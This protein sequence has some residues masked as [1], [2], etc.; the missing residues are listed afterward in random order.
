MP[1]LLTRV[2]IFLLVLVGAL[3]VL[4]Q[5]LRRTSMFYPSPY[6]IGNWSADAYGIRP[7]DEWFRT[8]D[9][10]RLHGW[11]F[12]AADPQAPLIV[13]FH[14]NGGNITDRAPIAVDLARAGASVLLFDYRGYG[15][16]EG[17]ASE[18]ALYDD[19]D[20]AYRL[21]TNEL[22]VPPERIVLYGE[23]LGGPYAA[24]VVSTEKARC[25][26]IENSFPSLSAMGNAMYHPLPAGIFVPGAMATAKW[27]NAAKLPVLILHGKR[28]QVIP[29]ALG[30]Q[31]FD[32][33]RV[34]KRMFVS[35]RAGHCEIPEVEG[36]R[37][38]AAV[39]DFI[40]DPR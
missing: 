13:W 28:D 15:R 11:L 35:E 18:S 21:A 40:R 24:H 29:F 22:H 30:Q 39:I 7:D 5:V 25:V 12:R 27:L 6:P 33:L 37:Y 4:A 2:A 31:L 10:V 14:G 1:P 34:P 17:T 9:G 38:V 8:R 32:E 36:G 16:S 19:A 20:A 23:S 26:V 3:Y